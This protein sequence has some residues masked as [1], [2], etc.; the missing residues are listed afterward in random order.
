MLLLER[1]HIPQ[2]RHDAAV[3]ASRHGDRT[4]LPRDCADHAGTERLVID[5]LHELQGL[6][7]ATRLALHRRHAAD[8]L[9]AQT[10]VVYRSRDLQRRAELARL[11]L[12]RGDRGAAS[13]RA[14]ARPALLTPAAG[15]APGLPQ[16]R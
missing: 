3:F 15:R 12:H 8:G 7:N 2:G 5:G 11:R 14:S 1:L 6:G 16:R 4:Q 10:F 9:D 13:R